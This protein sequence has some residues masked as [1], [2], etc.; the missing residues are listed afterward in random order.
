MKLPPSPPGNFITGHL[1][2]FKNDPISFMQKSYTEY[3]DMVLFKLLNKKIY[4]VNNPEAI[5]HV[6]HSNY[7][8]YVK[9][10]GYRPLR[11][12]G[13]MGIFTNDGEEWVRRRKFY[14]PAFSHS[15]ISS[16]SSAVLSNAD[17]MIHHWEQQLE[18]SDQINVSVE[19][20]KITMNIIGE[21]LFST[22]INYGSDLWNK[23]TLAL[24][25]ISDRALRNPF[26]MPANWPSKKNRAFHQ[27]V[28]DL[29]KVIYD[30]IEKK[31]SDNTNPHDLLS[32]FMNPGETNLK[33]L[34]EQELRDEVMT[35]FIAGHETSANVLSWAYYLLAQDA[36]I[37]NKVFNEVSALGNRPLKFEDLYHLR[38]TAQVLNETMR[39][40]P[41]VWH[42]GRM[43]IGPDEIAGYELPAGS[44]VRIC[45]LTLHRSKEFWNDP[46]RFNPDRFE[47][48]VFKEQHP[49]T[50]I[51]FGAGP[52]LCAGRNFAMMEMVLI[53]ASTIRKF[54][55][56]YSGNPIAMAPLMTLRSK[57]DI[58]LKLTKRN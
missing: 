34:N 37:Q 1:S 3:G 35:I 8:N 56:N 14:Q 57:G 2:G 23:T 25:W 55:F 21:T 16:Y 19:M 46:E 31:K 53:L 27:A 49:F 20:L 32:R 38:Y 28:A 50:F 22:R 40:Y 17:E 5:K 52:R 7:K 42:L 9:S 10:P 33:A 48:N 15:S 47:E 4:F 6:M 54:K 26:V 39:L 11:L 51:P 29:N 18:K 44:H 41:P 24:E 45:P 30:I 13:G 36:D 12:L 58:V 43:N